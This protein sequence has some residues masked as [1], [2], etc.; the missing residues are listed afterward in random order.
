MI[1][2]KMDVAVAEMSEALE[3]VC[4]GCGEL[5]PG[6]LDLEEGRLQLLPCCDVG[7]ATIEAEGF[8]DLLDHRQRKA[9]VWMGLG[10][11][12]HD[13]VNELDD[14]RLIGPI[15]HRHHHP[16]VGDKFRLGAYVD[17]D[18]IGVAI[19]GRPVGRWR[20]PSR[21][22]EVTRVAILERDLRRKNVAS[23]LYGAVCRHGADMGYGLVVTY[24]LASEHGHSLRAAGFTQVARIRGRGWGCRSRP[25]QDKHPICD[26]FR[27]ERVIG[28]R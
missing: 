8:F 7:I 6:G 26:K 21:I 16:P 10:A 11:V 5:L 3:E 19:A 22:L 14:W 27:Y 17:G 15:D 28:Q 9:L 20:D 25:R 1:S 13:V 4:P 12:C 2:S 18:L 24:T 23:A